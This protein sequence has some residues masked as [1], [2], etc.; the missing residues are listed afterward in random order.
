[1]NRQNLLTVKSWTSFSSLT[2]FSFKALSAREGPS[3]SGG[4]S[5]PQSSPAVLWVAVLKGGG[6]PLKWREGA[7]NEEMPPSTAKVT[8][9]FR[10]QEVSRLNSRQSVFSHSNNMN[11]CK[12]VTKYQ[13][14]F[15]GFY[16][17]HLFTS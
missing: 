6:H 9:T 14:L 3:S 12:A 2:A 16:L 8:A 17:N 11:N 10:D 15:S 4:S 5:E 1:M 7:R 13:R